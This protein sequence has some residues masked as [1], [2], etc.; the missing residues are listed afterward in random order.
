MVAAAPEVGIL[1]DMVSVAREE[2][3]MAVAFHE[4]WKP[5]D[6]MLPAVDRGGRVWLGGKPETITCIGSGAMTTFG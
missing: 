6:L 4:V 3:D 2:F 1:R 5:A